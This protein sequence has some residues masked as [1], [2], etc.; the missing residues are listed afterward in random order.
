MNFLKASTIIFPVT[1]L[2]VGCGDWQKNPVASNDLE[3]LRANS[4]KVITHGPDKPIEIVKTEVVEK[5]IQ[6]VREESSVDDK[7]IVITPDSQMTFNE[8]QETSFKV[9]A[10]VLI[11]NIQIKLTAQGLPEGAV[12][13][14]STKE[15]DLYIIRWKP[16][17]YTVASNAN[18]KSYEVKVIAEVSSVSNENTKYRGLIKE[19]DLSL[20]VFKNQ[21]APKEVK[22]SG[23]SSE[24]SEGTVTP[25]AVTVTV[26]GTDEKSPTKPRL[27]VSYDGVSVSAGNNFQELDGSR[28]VLADKSKNEIEYVGNSQWKFNL[29]Y[30]TK[31]ILPLPQLSKT[32]DP[33]A[34]ADGVRVRLSFKVVSPNQLTTP[35][36]LKQVKIKFA[37]TAASSA[38][39]TSEKT[40][41][42]ETEQKADSTGATA[43]GAK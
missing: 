31:N 30:D 24:I 15:K 13:E 41:N 9:Y 26:P 19:R 1:M 5:E 32:G 2:L 34:S 12:L 36:V 21:E 43:G 7:F 42:N 33:I 39:T 25:F 3:M 4:K 8:G 17:L 23:L 11:P 38:D 22:L 35:E 29:L 20:F 16:A 37:K 28:H 40:S 27:L 10:R 18:M 14:A 6:V